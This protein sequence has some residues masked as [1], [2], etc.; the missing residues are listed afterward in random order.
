MGFRQLL[1]DHEQAR[2]LL[3]SLGAHGAEPVTV[4]ALR[5]LL[6]RHMSEEEETLIPLVRRHLPAHTGPVA[7]ILEEHE[8][9]RRLLADLGENPG[10]GVVRR[11]AEL[12]SSHFAK[13]E[14]LLIPFAI[15]K[16]AEEDPGIGE[17]S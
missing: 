6:E 12:L 10:E 14:E 4:A 9:H 11:L 5:S 3:A 7:V 13:E 16:K 17:G 8:A 1:R 2:V 15:R